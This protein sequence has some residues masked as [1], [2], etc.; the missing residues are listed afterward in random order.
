MPYSSVLRDFLRRN[1]PDQTA[2]LLVR[3]AQGKAKGLCILV[4]GF[5]HRARHLRYFADAFAADGFDV[6]LFDYCT[7]RSGIRRHA[8]DFLLRFRELAAERLDARNIRVLTHSMGGLVFRAAM[9]AMTEEERARIGRVVMLAPPNR[10]SR[11]GSLACALGLRRLLPALADMATFPSAFVH[12][13]PPMPTSR[14]TGIV[15]ARRDGKVHAASVV[16]RDFPYVLTELDGGH[17]DLLKSS[18]AFDA[19]RRFFDAGAF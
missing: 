2:S 16:P 17:N 12:G 5:A 4:H 1:A 10:G 7:F 9:N 18:R 11:W 13:I 3:P 8:E 15:R 6:A 14:P 19:A